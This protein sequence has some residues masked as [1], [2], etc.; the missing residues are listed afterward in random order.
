MEHPISD[1]LTHR[2]LHEM[3]VGI[4]S[5]DNR[6]PPEKDIAATL[7]VSRTAIR[8]CLSI[9]EREGFINR[10]Q[11]VGTMINRHVM[12]TPTRM[13]IER[14]FLDMIAVTGQ[15]SKV[16]SVVVS[17]TDANEEIALALNITIGDKVLTVS[18]VVSANGVPTI[19]CI[20]H[21]AKKIVL[22][23]T[24]KKKDLAAPIFS[25]L[26]KFCS[27]EVYMDLTEVR[28]IV[29]TSNVASALDLPLSSPVLHMAEVG[30]SFFGDP[31]LFSLE[32]YRDGILHHK[33]VR[34]RM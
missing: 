1:Q 9:L 20:D 22:N 15:V 26:K 2:L 7:G 12:R 13:D 6:L 11:G 27:T 31:V 16:E 4:Y 18:R 34:K 17:E 3:R 23:H 29:A 32:Y 30:Y 28:A 24:Y 5:N 21:I 14:E 25:F 8:D 10:K 19:Y 33:L